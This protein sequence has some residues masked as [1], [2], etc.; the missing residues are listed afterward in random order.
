MT[1]LAAV[2]LAL[3]LTLAGTRAAAQQDE[4]Q[5]AEQA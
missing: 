1:R 3:A 2:A 4:L 5:L